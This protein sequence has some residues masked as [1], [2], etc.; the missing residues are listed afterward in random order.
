MALLLFLVIVLIVTIG[1]IIYMSVPPTKQQQG[2][3]A[4]TV[5]ACPICRDTGCDSCNTKPNKKRKRRCYMC[6]EDPC[7]C[8]DNGSE[9]QPANYSASCS[10]GRC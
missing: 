5:P 7:Q 8:A 2:N 6:E 1:I 3:A 4:A 10:T 9:S